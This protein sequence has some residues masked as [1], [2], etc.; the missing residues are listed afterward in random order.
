MRVVFMGSPEFAVP[1]LEILVAS[2]FE[3]AAVYAQ[4]DRPAGR[5]RT[6][7]VSPVKQAAVKV[8]LPVIQPE[9]LRRPEEID[10]LA[11]LQPDVIVVAAYGQ[12]LPKAVLELPPLGCVNIHPS[13]LP[14]H[15]GASPVPAAILAGDEFTGV[16]I[17]KL[18]EGM[19]TGP[20]ITRARIPIAGQDTTGTLV[21]KLAL[22]GADLMLD[23]LV[24]WARG[25]L[26]LQPQDNGA[27]TY[28][29]LIDKEKGLIDWQ[30]PAANIW[31]QIRAYQP[32]P[33]AFTLWQGKR[34]EILKGFSLPW[35]GGEE[36]GKIVDLR[37]LTSEAAFG[38]VTGDGVLGVCLLKLEGKK[39]L[40]ARA[41]LN[42][43]RGFIGSAVAN[44]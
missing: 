22:I 31:R 25:E 17:M 20:V 19:D 24:Y 38:I 29:P 8:G 7:N 2:R 27:A 40:E 39:I 35:G 3:I 36:V 42:G 37:P 10:R 12:I 44:V 34:L 14:R 9:K 11:S 18:D 13:L 33:G 1:A 23:V 43:Q 21:E 30:Q 4:P 41:F 15:R 16:S 26:V 28:S 6:L 32:W 5:G